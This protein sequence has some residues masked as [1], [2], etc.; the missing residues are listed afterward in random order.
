MNNFYKKIEEKIDGMASRTWLPPELLR[1]AGEITRAQRG[2]EPD[3]APPVI[4]VDRL[5]DAVA[6]GQGRPLL[7][8]EFFP[9]DA[10]GAARLWNTL[11]E[12][13]AAVSGPAG[14]TAR[15]ARLRMEAREIDPAAAFAAYTRGDAVWFAQWEARYPRAP[16][17]IRFL[18]QSALTPW[19]EAATRQLAARHDADA[20]WE[21]GCCPHCGQWPF[22]GQLRG[23][24][25]A[26]WHVCSFCRLAYRAARLQCPVCL[27]KDAAK[28]RFFTVDR[29]PGYEAHV[30]ETCKNYIKL[31]DLKGK[32]SADALPPLDDLES[33][34]LDL[35]AR[36]QGYARST[37]SAWGF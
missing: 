7:A 26:R 30:C 1:L 15:A 13:A 25:G 2:A 35:A 20:V 23:K 19:L 17:M 37:A 11:L 31:L 5:A 32:N 34:P 27:E 29:E 16:S 33:L 4:P 8:P 6:H 12:L 3:M 24:E 9:Y 18:A 22:I 14:E 28:L 21:H 10:A 36:Q